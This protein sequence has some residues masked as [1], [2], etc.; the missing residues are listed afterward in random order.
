MMH[1]FLWPSLLK[2][3]ILYFRFPS[4]SLLVLIIA[5]EVATELNFQQNG[6]FGQLCCGKY[7]G[8]CEQCGADVQLAAGYDCTRD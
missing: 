2:L 1:T 4:P 7:G 8:K 5:A 3:C 6:V